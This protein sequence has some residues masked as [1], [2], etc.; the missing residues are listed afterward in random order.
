MG[1]FVCTD[2]VE[3]DVVQNQTPLKYGVISVGS[4]SKQEESRE[5]G[6]FTSWYAVYRVA[7][8]QPDHR[9]DCGKE[10]GSDANPV[11]RELVLNRKC[12]TYRR[13][14][15]TG[16]FDT[17]ILKSIQGKVKTRY[18]IMKKS[19]ESISSSQEYQV[20]SNHTMVVGA[21]NV[22]P[23]STSLSQHLQ[24]W[25]IHLPSKCSCNTYRRQ[26]SRPSLICFGLLVHAVFDGRRCSVDNVLEENE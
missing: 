21:G 20:V 6:L 23:S 13:C 7:D 12:L 25:L 9:E 15:T 10:Q 17:E 8:E 18:R 24:R 3:G 5:V 2:G 22:H 26:D 4:E 16:C 11:N 19:C 1:D 14:R